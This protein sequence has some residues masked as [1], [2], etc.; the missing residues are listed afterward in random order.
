V[1]ITNISLWEIFLNAD[2]VLIYLT[3]P[4]QSTMKRNAMALQETNPMITNMDR[5]LINRAKNK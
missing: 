3:V 5:E 1:A 2:V 4:K